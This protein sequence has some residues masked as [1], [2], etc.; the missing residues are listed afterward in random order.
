MSIIMSKIIPLSY[1][2]MIN[3][4]LLNIFNEF[5]KIKHNN[6]T[7]IVNHFVNNHIDDNKYRNLLINKIDYKLLYYNTHNSNIN[8]ILVNKNNIEIKNFKKFN[9]SEKRI[10]KH[11]QIKY[12]D[13]PDS[14]CN[15]KNY[16]IK[17][18]I[19]NQSTSSIEGSS[20]V[21]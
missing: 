3:N 7:Y 14:I 4:H 19:K 17:N 12:Y 1:T 5:N 13:N 6:I 20:V 11:Y 21:S 9:D 2:N 18:H 16:Y 15:I 8:P 10:I